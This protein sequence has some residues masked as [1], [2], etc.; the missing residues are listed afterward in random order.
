MRCSWKLWTKLW[1][2]PRVQIILSN[3][4]SNCHFQFIHLYCGPAASSKP[5]AQSQHTNKG[6][7]FYNQHQSPLGKQ[8][9]AWEY[10]IQRYLLHSELAALSAYMPTSGVTLRLSKMGLESI[11]K[12]FKKLHLRRNCACTLFGIRHQS[13][14][15]LHC[16]YILSIENKTIWFL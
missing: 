15:S 10:I 5:S 13:S 16:H 11:K 12:M 9:K 3:Y 6:V 4:F 7:L 14:R 8:T 1:S 2:G